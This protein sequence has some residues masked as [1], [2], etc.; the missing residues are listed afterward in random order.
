MFYRQGERFGSTPVA[1]IP[2]GTV[3]AE[4]IAEFAYDCGRGPWLAWLGSS[5]VQWVMINAPLE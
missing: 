3:A 4:P 2:S 1:I 5:L